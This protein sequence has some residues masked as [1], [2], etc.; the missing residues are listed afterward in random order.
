MSAALWALFCAVAWTVGM[1]YFDWK[2]QKK[3]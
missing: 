2:K 3:K 1:L